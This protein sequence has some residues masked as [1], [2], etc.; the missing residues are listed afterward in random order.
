[1]HRC[2][3]KPLLVEGVH[4][5]NFVVN[6]RRAYGT[7]KLTG[8]QFN[9]LLESQVKDDFYRYLSDLDLGLTDGDLLPSSSKM[10]GLESLDAKC[11]CTLLCS[12]TINGPTGATTDPVDVVARL[13]G[14]HVIPTA[15]SW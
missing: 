1:M 6:H 4:H 14:P 15:P 10:Q 11:L 5:H 7:T 9:F 2:L 12:S 13:E 3:W 8:K